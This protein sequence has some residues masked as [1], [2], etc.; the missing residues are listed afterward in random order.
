MFTK[1]A[2]CALCLAI[3]AAAG[4]WGQ[5]EASLG[6]NGKQ[7]V[8]LVKAGGFEK[9]RRYLDDGIAETPD[10]PVLYEYL[11]LAY[12]DCASGIDMK[13]CLTKA[14]EYMD[15]AIALGGRAAVIADRYTTG[16]GGFLGTMSNKGDVTGVVR[17]MLYIYKDRI[18]F[19]PKPGPKAEAQAV[20]LQAAEIK[21]GG[22]GMNSVVGGDVNTFHIKTKAVTCNFR[23]ANFS[24]DEAQL[25]FQLMEKYQGIRAP[26][27]KKGNK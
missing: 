7:G 1:R 19:A 9:A 4:C 24:A 12:L 20:T 2:L 25:I 11:G 5:P 6:E 14:G 13:R 18:E 16:K 27:P 23:T 8:D 15:K 3:G 17:G 21:E 22:T 10:N 26:A